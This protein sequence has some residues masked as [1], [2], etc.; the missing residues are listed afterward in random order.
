MRWQLFHRGKS[1]SSLLQAMGGGFL[2][3]AV[4][5]WF[6]SNNNTIFLR[7]QLKR[8]SI[9]VPEPLPRA[10]ALA[11]AVAA[12]PPDF[13]GQDGTW[14]RLANSIAKRAYHHAERGQLLR[15]YLGLLD[16]AS[17]PISWCPVEG[18]PCNDLVLVTIAGQQILLDPARGGA[19]KQR[20]QY[21]APE[22]LN[23]SWSRWPSRMPSSI[24]WAK[25]MG[26]IR[27]WPAAIDRIDVLLAKLLT[28]GFLIVIVL[29]RMRN[30]LNRKANEQNQGQ[31]TD[32]AL[33][34]PLGLS[35]LES[36]QRRYD[37]DELHRAIDE[38]DSFVGEAAVEQPVSDMVATATKR[39]QTETQASDDELGDLDKRQGE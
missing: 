26:L 13:Y 15:V 18:Q 32:D 24:A 4:V 33:A 31:H 1:P 17:Q 2:I 35:K 11:D 5:V 9:S 34:N 22:Q 14:P 36:D 39:A 27:S 21:L 38:H 29:I 16:K 30:W 19:L 10:L 37:E 3:A 25:S 8:H 12:V 6:V 23:G 20:G 28:L 7:V